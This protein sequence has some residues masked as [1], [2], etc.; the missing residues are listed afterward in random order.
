MMVQG[1]FWADSSDKLVYEASNDPS[2]IFD[3]LEVHGIHFRIWPK[4]VPEPNFGGSE[5]VI[6]RIGQD[7]AGG[8]LGV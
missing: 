1:P 4:K 7:P 8:S 2:L 6:E 3:G 5:P